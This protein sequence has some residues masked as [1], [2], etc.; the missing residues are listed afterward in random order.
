M[1][2][3][4]LAQYSSLLRG[5]VRLRPRASSGPVRKALRL[6]SVSASRRDCKLHGSTNSH[7]QHAG[8]HEN[9]V[10]LVMTP[11]LPVRRYAFRCDPVCSGECSQDA[12]REGSSSWQARCWDALRAA[13]DA[14]HAEVMLGTVLLSK[15]SP[16]VPCWVD[17]AISH[18]DEV[19]DTDWAA[20]VKLQPLRGRCVYHFFSGLCGRRDGIA[21]YNSMLWGHLSR[22]RLGQRWRLQLCR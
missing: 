18:C 20:L 17:I 5:K 13:A 9:R 10:S 11:R 4:S 12:D 15:C 14:G 1:T 8:P 21:A 2:P 6:V 7:S 19:L 3:S 16:T 22:V